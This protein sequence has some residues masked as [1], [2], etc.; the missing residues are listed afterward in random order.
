M[1]FNTIE[2]GCFVTVDCGCGHRALWAE[3][4][5][6]GCVGCWH[7]ALGDVVV[8]LGCCGGQWLLSA[9]GSG[10]RA[11]WEVPWAAATGVFALWESE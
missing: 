8:T 10:C 7:L 11:L 4:R 5:L 2:C 6:S 1:Q 9:M 3:S